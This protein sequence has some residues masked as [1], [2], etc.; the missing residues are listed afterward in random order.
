MRKDTRKTVIALSVFAVAVVFLF[1]RFVYMERHDSALLDAVIAGN[2]PAARKAFGEGATMTMQIRR[3][4]T[5]L[6]VA[7]LHTNVEIAKLLV[8][9]GAAETLT[10]RNDDGDT[11][12]DIALAKGHAEMADYLR[13]LTATNHAKDVP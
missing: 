5:F 2:V 6:Q 10:A 12:L 9:H 8:E 11:A 3:H 1:V 7:S 4:F 13:S